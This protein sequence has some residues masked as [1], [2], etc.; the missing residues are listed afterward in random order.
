MKYSD[1]KR[2]LVLL[3]VNAH[4]RACESEDE[5]NAADIIAALKANPEACADVLAGLEPTCCRDCRENLLTRAESAE[6]ERDEWRRKWEELELTRASCCDRMER[7]RDEARAERERLVYLLRSVA[8]THGLGDHIKKR[9]EVEVKQEPSEEWSP[10]RLRTERDAA[11]Q[12]LAIERAA[13]EKAERERNALR[14]ALT[15]S[16]EAVVTSMRARIAELEQ[17]TEKAEADLAAAVRS[18]GNDGLWCANVGEHDSVKARLEKA[19]AVVEAARHRSYVFDP[20]AWQRWRNK[21]R[22]GI[23]AFDKHKTSSDD[24][25]GV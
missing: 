17:R 6:R 13:R 18:R 10:Y 16:Q 20:L 14:S 2:T 22:A 21:L 12:E 23:A 8:R 19:E 1:G 4:S 7:E 5:T 9:I 25:G 15:D 11:R 3:T 24:N